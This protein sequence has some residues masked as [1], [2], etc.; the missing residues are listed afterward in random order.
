MAVN[1]AIDREKGFTIAEVM[2][3]MVILTVGLVS[4]L[5]LFSSAVST[6]CRGR[7]KT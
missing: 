2:T 3:A 5:T 6:M 4:V 1:M 7:R